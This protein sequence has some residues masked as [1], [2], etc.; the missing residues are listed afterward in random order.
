[1]C[2]KYILGTK[3]GMTTAIDEEG[4][5]VPVTIV[6]GSCVVTDVRTKERD[7]Y[8]AVQLGCI[9][10]RKLNKAEIGH[11]KKSGGLFRTLREFRVEQVEDT[12]SPEIG[13]SITVAIFQKGDIVKVR[14][15]IKAKGFTGTVKRWGFKGGP[16]SH[17]HPHQR[18]PGS[19]GSAYPQHV[20]KGSKMAGR[21]GPDTKSILGLTVF[22]VDVDNN[23]LLIKGS[24]PGKRG[25]LLE[26][27]S[28]K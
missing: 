13:E 7:A 21:K 14:G 22:D 1:M 27:R 3:F 28:M 5:T 25:G 9:P 26:V 18:K 11:L 2:M 19:I 8:T 4:N 17:G 20:M 6:V 15:L 12:P 23:A 24:V 16:A 10:T